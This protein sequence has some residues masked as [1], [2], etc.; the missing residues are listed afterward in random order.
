MTADERAG[1]TTAMEMLGRYPLQTKLGQGGM[2]M[3]Y[4]AHDTKA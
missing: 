2:G 1:A 3:V 4:L